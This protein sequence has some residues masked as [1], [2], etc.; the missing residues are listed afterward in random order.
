M[1]KKFLYISASVLVA[2]A[3]FLAVFLPIKFNKAKDNNKITS[4]S[5]VNANGAKLS[6]DEL[7]NEK[8]DTDSDKNK[9]VVEEDVITYVDSALDGEL[10]LP[11]SIVGIGAN[12]FKYSK[13]QAVNF[14]EGLVTISV[15]AFLESSLIKLSLPSTVTTIEKDAFWNCTS[16]TNIT[17]NDGLQ[18]IGYNAFYNCQF[19]SLIIPSSVTTIEEGAFI[20]CNKIIGT[21]TLPQNITVIKNSTFKG[22][23]SVK[24]FVLGNVENIEFQAFFECTSLEKINLPSTLTSIQD[25]AFRDC[26]KLSTLAFPI[27]LQSIG[28][29]T[30]DGCRSLETVTLNQNIAKLGVATFSNCISLNS[31]NIPQSINSI[32][33]SCFYGCSSLT[34]IDLSSV[35]IIGYNAFFGC[36]NVTFVLDDNENVHYVAS[37]DKVFSS[38]EQISNDKFKEYAL[39]NYYIKKVEGKINENN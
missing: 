29:H 2:T 21:V 32:P 26:T 1:N 7:L 14:N 12:A 38:L 31:I 24:E 18:V 34:S 19:T 4:G 3:A 39:K 16:L 28:S 6:W 17:L 23:S 36:K 5:L 25:D 33:D 8:S 22:C 11:T 30:F 27:A 13:L 35:E 15:G 20:N 10:T 37:K 9:I